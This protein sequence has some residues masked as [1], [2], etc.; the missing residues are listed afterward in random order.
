MHILIR[1]L[2]LFFVITQLCPFHLEYA[3]VGSE[4]VAL[5][6]AMFKIQGFYTY[7]RG[8]E[9]VS[10]KTFYCTLL[11]TILICFHLALSLECCIL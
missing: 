3:A 11:F 5:D 4:A 10:L 1:A 8:T 2:H 6:P 7:F 9:K